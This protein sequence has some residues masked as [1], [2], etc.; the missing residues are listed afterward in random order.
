[1]GHAADAALAAVAAAE[2]PQS[3]WTEAEAAPTADGPALCWHARGVTT[4]TARFQLARI[5]HATVERLGDLLRVAATSLVAP[6]ARLETASPL[7]AAE[8]T[9]VVETWNRTAVQ[10][11]TEATV[12][13]LFREQAAAAPE[14]IALVWDG[15]RMT[16]G[17]LDRWSDALAERLIAVGVGADQPVALC[18]PRSPE[19][20]V[21]AL[22]ILKAGGAYLPL[23]P[24]HP[25]ERLAFAIGD[26]G[27]SVLVTRRELAG[28]LA[29]LASRTVF[30]EDAA[31][32]PV[33]AEPRVERATPRTRAYVMYTS[34]STGVPKGVQIEHRS[35]VRLVGR[36]TY[37]RLDAETRFLHAAPLGFDAS[38]LELWGPLLHGGACVI[39]A[40]PVPTGRGLARA[41]AAHGVTTMWLT[42]ALFNSVVDE[43]PRLLSGV[44]QLFTGGEALSPSHVRRALAALPATELHNGYGP[45]ECT[46]FTTTHRIP[47]D[48]PADV[49][50]P[51]GAPIG[52]TQC[53]VLSRAGAP[54]PVGIAG[55]LFVGGLG[56]A[57]GY[58]ARPELD[59]E[60]FVPDH[61]G[62]GE[63]LYRTG[64]R[65]RWRPDGTLDFLG[66]ADNQVKLR[67]FRIELGEIEARLGALPGI[68]ACAVILRDDGPGGKRLVAYVVPRGPDDDAPAVDPQA[69]SPPAL[70]AALGRLLPDFMV[71]AQFVTLDA[72]PI[73]A[74]GKL[75]RR[76]LPAPT[77]ARPELAQPYR[78]PSGDREAA[79]CR[80][81]GDVLGLDQVGALDGFFELGGN[82][83]LSLRLLARLR[84]AGLPE[85]SPAVFFAAPT[86]AALA[87]A[88]D[89]TAGTAAP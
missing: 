77:S 86:P 70:R 76:R 73:T 84:E 6:G 85:V 62:D 3:A 79:I 27:A 28:A 65:V 52:D 58:L 15:G 19:A 59:A 1:R 14:R 2:P 24:D 21:A 56:V 51:I 87:R 57:R 39:Y 66:R 67:G 49:P 43:D 48:L 11:R 78:A 10:Y 5:E 40:D 89:G 74:N 81:F 75:D 71:P 41:I 53:Y 23:D 44:R 45:T 36:P 54:V 72:L 34:G 63:L 61:L 37:V 22:A 50:I 33:S 26:A 60:R 68:A 55:E 20:I 31:A 30:V 9:R 80:A 35:I 82:S 18:V 42:A 25:A 64:D 12:H 69:I 17:E 46:T 47:R 4:A 38:T 8:R 7:S 88:I 29:Q 13:G 83:L 16:Y 32:D